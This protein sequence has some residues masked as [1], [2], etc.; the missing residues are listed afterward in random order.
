MTGLRAAL[1]AIVGEDHVTDDPAARALASA[2]LFDWPE[3]VTAALVVR[4]GSG[5]ETAAVL[6]ALAAAGM[7]AV[8]RGAGLSYTAGCVP[9]QPSVVVETTRLTGVEID[10]ESLVAVAGAGAPWATVAEAAARRGLRLVMGGP[11]SG[12]HAT[13]G[14][15]ASQ[16]IPAGLDSVTGL[17]VALADGGL[18]R[19]GAWA[20]DGAPP[21]LRGP[22]PDLTGLFLGDCGALGVKTRVALRLRPDQPARFASFRFA[23]GPRVV[24]AVAAVARAGLAVRAFAMDALKN[25]TAASV[26][27]GEAVRTAGAV[28]ARAGTLGEAWRGAVGMARAAT[29]ALESVPWSL[30]LT[31]EGPSDAIAKAQLDLARA[32]ARDAGGT[33]IDDVVPRGLHGRPYSIRGMVG[34]DGERWVPVHGIFALGRAAPAMAA[35]GALSAAEADALERHGI[36]VSYIVS[37]QGPYVT[38]EPMFYWRDALDAIHLRYLAPRHRER[39]GGFAADTAA[40]DAV[41]RLRRQVEAEMD[42]HGAAHVQVGRFY[43]LLDRI[44]EP[45][46][47]LLCRVK[48]ALDPENR[49]NPGALGL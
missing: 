12:V 34:V 37:S 5:P 26:G 33:E 9:H 16:G 1:A 24:G 27:A 46:R 40:R 11:I 42:R 17:E 44:G 15:T 13:V 14:G 30:H 29:G 8:P 36:A 18:A 41:R 7:P 28:L 25:R 3:A 47:A 48:R 43:G 22:G 32:L 45:E 10:A 20:L 38:I 19:T 39:F 4:P 2:D 35:L 23:E 21:F 49:L 6:G 31:A